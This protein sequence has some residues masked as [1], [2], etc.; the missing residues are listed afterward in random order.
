LQIIGPKGDSK[1]AWRG[2]VCGV[3]ACGDGRL[4]VTDG[5][6]IVVLS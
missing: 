4:F 3:A 5:T 1:L 6:S 2:E